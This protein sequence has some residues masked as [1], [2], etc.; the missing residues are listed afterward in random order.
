MDNDCFSDCSVAV[1]K[2]ALFT[3]HQK[4]ASAFMICLGR[5]LLYIFL[6]DRTLLC[7]EDFRGT[8]ESI[9]WHCSEQDSLMRC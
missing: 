6:E 5:T 8:R 9:Y 2:Y 4:S 7:G 3:L 1:A